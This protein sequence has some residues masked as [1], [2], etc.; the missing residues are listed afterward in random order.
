MRRGGRNESTSSIGG[1]VERAD[2]STRFTMCAPSRAS[3]RCCEKS[4]STTG[5]LK[6]V[7][8]KSQIALYEREN[9]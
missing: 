3:Q 5:I 6:L 1:T 4:A 8:A 9:P 2:D 7:D